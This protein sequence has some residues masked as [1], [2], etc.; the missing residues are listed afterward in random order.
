M[1]KGV[2]KAIIEV[3][4]TGN[5]YFEK[6][7]LFVKSDYK[8]TSQKTLEKHAKEFI[9]NQCSNNNTNNSAPIY[10]YF[11]L[12]QDRKRKRRLFLILGGYLLLIC[13]IVM[14]IIMR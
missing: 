4:D 8:N 12:K 1:I 6:A 9:S 7:I 5:K 3:N 13:A 10:E 2:N 14:A 11:D